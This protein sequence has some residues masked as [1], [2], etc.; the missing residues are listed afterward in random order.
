[1]FWIFKRIRI[2]QN[3]IIC[4]STVNNI[5]VI[6]TTDTIDEEKIKILEDF[7]DLK[8]NQNTPL[9]VLHRRTLMV[10]EKC[11]HKMKV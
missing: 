8:I 7:K 10:R 9:R 1:M 2:E 3:K 11:I 4:S 5:K 6:Y